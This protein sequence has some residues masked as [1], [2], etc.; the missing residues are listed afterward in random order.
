MRTNYL[1]SIFVVAAEIKCFYSE[2]QSIVLEYTFDNPSSI[3]DTH[4]YSSFHPLIFN[5][6]SGFVFYELV[7]NEVHELVIAFC[8]NNLFHIRINFS[9]PILFGTKRKCPPFSISFSGDTFIPTQRYLIGPPLTNAKR[10]QLSEWSVKLRL[11][12]DRSSRSKAFQKAWRENAKPL[13]AQRLNVLTGAFNKLFRKENGLEDLRKKKS[14]E[15]R[16]VIKAL[17][18]SHLND[19]GRADQIK[20]QVVNPT[21]KDNVVQIILTAMHGVYTEVQSGMIVISDQTR[22][23]VTEVDIPA[24]FESHDQLKLAREW[25]DGFINTQNRK[26]QASLGYT[27]KRQ[28]DASNYSIVKIM[29]E[30]GFFKLPVKLSWN[31][32]FSFYHDPDPLKNQ[33]TWR[34]A[35]AALSLE[36][37]SSSPFLKDTPDLS[38]I[39][40]SLTGRYQRLRENRGTPMKADIGVAQFKVE[41]PIAAGVSIPLS[42]SAA[43]ATELLNESKVHG[44]FG[45]TFDL[46]KFAA[47][48]KLLK[49]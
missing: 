8:A 22:K 27:F 48:R 26:P 37:K 41:F 23:E 28:E 36:A 14:D 25:V 12:R 9:A 2:P 5:F 17:L 1:A 19:P 20:Q 11:N 43:T 49:R 33:E 3:E 32:S 38:K 44:H 6:R 10:S 34:D 7:G 13:I 35:S 46:D 29:Y 47:V 15:L 31:T 4:S 42:I 30:Q 40:Y 16:P 21:I 39:T 18:D 45:F 24:L